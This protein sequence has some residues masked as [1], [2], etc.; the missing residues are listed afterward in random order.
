MPSTV[1]I[2]GVIYHIE[3]RHSQETK[4]ECDGA[5]FGP[6]KP[7]GIGRIV[8]RAELDDR[9]AHQVLFHEITH[10]MLIAEGMDGKSWDLSEDELIELIDGHWAQVLSG[11]VQ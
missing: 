11:P 10:P 2:E 8:L 5:S 7:D 1:R 3:R 4:D 6:K 9:R